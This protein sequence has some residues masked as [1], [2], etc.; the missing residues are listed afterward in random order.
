MQIKFYEMTSKSNNKT[1]FSK[2]FEK[3]MLNNHFDTEVAWKLTLFIEAICK[4][5]LLFF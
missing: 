4:H 2:V 5:S 3:V 1:I